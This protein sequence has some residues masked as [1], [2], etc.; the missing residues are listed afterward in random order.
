MEITGDGLFFDYR[1]DNHL[2]SSL[3]KLKRKGMIEYPSKPL[4][5]LSD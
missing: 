5:L 1:G 4:I 2:A 3:A